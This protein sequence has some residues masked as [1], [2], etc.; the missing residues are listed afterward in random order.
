MHEMLQMHQSRQMRQ[1]PVSEDQKQMMLQRVDD[2]EKAIKK[3][4]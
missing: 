2:V 3:G 1:M 4:E